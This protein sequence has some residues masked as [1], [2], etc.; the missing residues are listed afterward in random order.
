MMRH[1]Q[2]THPA[3]WIAA[4]LA[5]LI[6]LSVPASAQVEIRWMAVGS[7][8]H[9]F[10]ATGHE[11]EE[12]RVAVQQD[13]LQW[14][15]YYKYQDVEAASGLWI[16]VTNWKDVSGKT[17]AQKV[18]HVGPRVN[19]LNEF[20]PV[21]FKTVSRFAPPQV[22]AD[23][24]PSTGGAPLSNTT[25]DPTLKCDRMII[26]I[27]NTAIG[28]T[29]TRKILAWSQTYND[30]YFIYEYTFTNTG[31]IDATAA[32][33]LS[34]QT[35][36]GL[37]VFIQSRY[38][39]TYDGSQEI[40]NP[41]S[42]G[43]NTM[44]DVRGDGVK[45]DPVGQ[46]FRCRYSWQGLFPTFTK[47]DNIGAPMF[48]PAAPA[49]DPAD[50]AGRLAAAQFVGTVTL[51]ADKSATDSTDDVTQPSTTTYFGS[52]EKNNPPTSL[53][54]QFDVNFMAAEY[55]VMSSGHTN[56]RH[57]DKVQPNGAFDVPTGDPSLGT[58]G[59]FSSADGYGPYT[60]APGQSIH[61]VCAEGVAGLSHEA[62]VR[63]GRAFK[64]AG[65]G[66]G[67]PAAKA[68]NDSVLTGR[69]S[70]F[71]TFA[72]ARANYTSGYNIPQAP[73]PPKT[74]NVVSAG[75]GVDVSWDVYGG[76]PLLQGFRLYRARDRSDGTYTLVASFGAAARSYK[77]TAL[78]RGFD[79]FYYLVSVG[80][81]VAAD[82][83]GSTPVGALLTSNRIMSQT[84]DKVNL[85]RSSVETPQ[86]PIRIVPNPYSIASDVASLRF[87]FR[88]AD[89]I[90]FFNIPGQC[91]IKV[92]TETGELIKEILH[93]N[94]SGDEYWNSNT[95]SGQ[96]IV[97]GVYIVVFEN[98][99]TGERVIRKLAVIR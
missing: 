68:K 95:S 84:Y 99:K 26:N 50:T 70:L 55:A 23:G 7:L 97:S 20:F 28:L 75:D 57:A 82:P 15:A 3:Q 67:T 60:L 38:A 14:P 21:T 11:I 44:N 73:L 42:W 64:A 71:Q 79:Y 54:S 32:A 29:M 58:S 18:V 39:C 59:G 93:T 86:P 88:E 74:F 69:D 49:S 76:D 25:I 22:F 24:N 65:G 92:Y 19:G 13:G 48:T 47:Y 85:L 34:T 17:W 33:P 56:P 81:P 89:R 94:G 96:V 12:G 30:N 80:A 98:M 9:W 10:A 4:G 35:L 72:R 37:Y 5:A 45:P 77:D 53:N 6:A 62:C 61:I 31:Q 90:A 43:I 51:H 8:N 87:G 40:G 66:V 46:Q 78:S 1:R 52:D 2:F 91:K 63:V 27:D 36:T 83:S 41:T 16:G